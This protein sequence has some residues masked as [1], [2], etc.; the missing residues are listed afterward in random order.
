MPSQFNPSVYVLGA[1]AD[2]SDDVFD[3]ACIFVTDA[4]NGMLGLKSS[5]ASNHYAQS[6]VVDVTAAQ[7]WITAKRNA[8]TELGLTGTTFG[9]LGD[10]SDQLF[11]L[12]IVDQVAGVVQLQ[13]VATN[14]FLSWVVGNALPSAQLP[15]V[16]TGNAETNAVSFV[17]SNRL[18]TIDPL[19]LLPFGAHTI[20]VLSASTTQDAMGSTFVMTVFDEYY[21]MLMDARPQANYQSR[22][23]SYGRAL[24]L[25]KSEV[26]LKVMLDELASMVNAAKQDK[27]SSAWKDF[28]SEDVSAKFVALLQ[29]ID[30]NFASMLVDESNAR[31]AF[32][33]QLDSLRNYQ[34]ADIV[35]NYQARL[36][37]LSTTLNTLT[38]DTVEAFMKDLTNFIADR[39]D[40]VV[41]VP[42]NGATPASL[43]L[44][45]VTTA[46][47]WLA[48]NVYY[49]QVLNQAKKRDALSA[50]IKKANQPVSFAEYVGYIDNR[51]ISGKDHFTTNE[52]N[53]V[54]NLL[55][56]MVAIPWLSYASAE[57]FDLG[58]AKDLLLRARANQMRG[59]QAS[60]AKL[61]ALLPQLVFP[62]IDGATY[63][64]MIT[65]LIQSMRSF[66]TGTPA[67][68]DAE[69]KLIAKAGLWKT[70]VVLTGKGQLDV[71]NY[72]TLLNGLLK[73]PL[74]SSAIAND[75][76][77]ILA[78]L[79][80][81]LSAQGIN[82]TIASASGDLGMPAS[83]TGSTGSTT[84]SS[85]FGS[86]GSSSTPSGLSI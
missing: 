79:S 72:A 62:L 47:T 71:F 51:W 77:P 6:I 48:E 40:G 85:L 42:A 10:F 33:Q 64:T 78:D 17:P 84:T 32:G 68:M 46:T 7:N 81:N 1:G 43:N 9:S 39:T 27:Q 34:D 53:Y 44:D 54:M 49:N 82:F 45:L 19:T 36:N 76:K 52:K 59:D 8:Q 31:N 15:A 75:L 5:L 14:G 55:S 50:L 56:N 29:L 3:P 13:N 57:D 86:V 80:A 60:V 66:D 70:R 21:K 37:T 83:S 12:V 24:P 16:V 20:N 35:L 23:S 25:I 11:K 74:I 69:K 18:R 73:D 4:K 58:V 63:T 26:E 65:A 67:F 22:F 28:T 41:V 30:D 2:G 61:N 38:L